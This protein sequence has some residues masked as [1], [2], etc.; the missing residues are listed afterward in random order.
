MN[1][2][3][4]VIGKAVEGSSA[5]RH[6]PSGQQAIGPLIEKGAGLL[7]VPR[8]REVLRRPLPYLDLPRH[9]P[10]D[11]DQLGRQCL[12]PASRGIVPEE[13]TLGAE[14][15]HQ[16]GDYCVAHGLEPG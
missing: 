7:A 10:L 13:D 4:A 5:L 15:F 1:R 11:L 6:E 3:R 8:C 16:S 2:E 12:A 9:S 14:H